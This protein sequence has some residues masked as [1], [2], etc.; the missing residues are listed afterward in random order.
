VPKNITLDMDSVKKYWAVGVG[1]LATALLPFATFASTPLS[2]TT[3]G[4]S[5]DTVSGTTMD[6]FGVLIE[7][8][9]PFLLG[10]VILVGVILFGKRIIHGMFGK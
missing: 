8:F 4:T 2:T 10:A 7:K 9:W 6:Y 3:L 5:I 1:A